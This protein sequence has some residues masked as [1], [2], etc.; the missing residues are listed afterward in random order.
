MLVDTLSQYGVASI[1]LLV[2]WFQIAPIGAGT[3][4]FLDNVL[5]ALVFVAAFAVLRL[6]GV[7]RLLATATMGVAVVTLVFGLEYP[8]GALLQHGAIRFGMPMFLIAAAT[9]EFARPRLRRPSQA[10]ELLAVGLASIWALEAFAYTVLTAA[11]ILAVRL[12]FAPATVRRRSLVRWI[13][14]SIAAC[15]AFHVTLVLGT[16]IAVGELPDWG[17]YLNTLRE[18]L[19]GSVGDLT[20]D[21][22][23]WTAAFAVGVLYVAAAAALFLVARNRPSLIRAHPARAIALAGT[24]AWGVALYS[25]FVNRSAEHIL[26]YV[27]LP[28]AMLIA[29]WLGLLL[30]RRQEHGLR[31]RLVGLGAAM[32]LGV[33]LIG[34]A[35][36]GAGSRLSQSALAYAV[37]G[38]G[39]TLGQGL[40]RLWNPPDLSPG[41]TAGAE[42]VE[43]CMP[44]PDRTYVLTDADLGIEL[45]TKAGR[46]NAF[47][48]SDPW[49]DSFVPDGHLDE[50]AASVDALRPG[51]RLLVDAPA[52]ATFD[53]YRLDPSRDPITDPLGEEQLVPTGLAKLQEWLLKEVGRRYRLETVCRAAGSAGLRVV[54]LEPRDRSPVVP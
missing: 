37:P 6:V 14:A 49:E 36:S 51:D 19:T 3:L 34:A 29:I 13:W 30:D 26:P 17:W 22:A 8:L 15:I 9:L 35:W 46:S 23:P 4:G 54:A 27:C 47:P 38:G 16:L 25:Y 52:L 40:D 28:A 42:L 18:F 50:L 5:S 32:A 2:G 39:P 11:A 20:Y 44:D 21:F 41:A 12:W 53:A 24:T 31:L 1:Y 7:S 43:R 33:L 48:L 45:L 10:V